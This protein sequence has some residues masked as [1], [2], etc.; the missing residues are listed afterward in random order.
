MSRNEAR[1]VENMNPGD[2]LD[3]ILEPLNTGPVEGGVQ[4]DTLSVNA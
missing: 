2:G 4:L 3:A 1:E